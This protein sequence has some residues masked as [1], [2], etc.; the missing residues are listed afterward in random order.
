[1]NQGSINTEVFHVVFFRFF[2][3]KVLPRRF[4]LLLLFFTSDQLHC[5]TV[6]VIV[7]HRRSID[8]SQA[9]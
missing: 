8:S 5:N 1:M 7:V 6:V 9:S 4:V 2:C 3:L